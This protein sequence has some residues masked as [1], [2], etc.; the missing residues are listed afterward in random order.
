MAVDKVHS[1]SAFGKLIVMSKTK[2][3]A[4]KITVHN[5]ALFILPAFSAIASNM[6]TGQ[7]YFT[8]SCCWW[9]SA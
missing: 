7:M 2:D 9:V 6:D 3:I 5:K 1:I 4:N 8:I